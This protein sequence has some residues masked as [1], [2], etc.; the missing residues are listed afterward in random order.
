MIGTLPAAA[1]QPWFDDTP[2]DAARDLGGVVDL[3]ITL[4]GA[5][6]A[7]LTITSDALTLAGNAAFALPQPPPTCELSKAAAPE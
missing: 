5:E 4:G 2:V 1:L 6:G 3:S 7:A